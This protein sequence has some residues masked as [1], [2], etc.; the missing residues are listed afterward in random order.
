MPVLKLPFQK[1]IKENLDAI[2][3]L[4]PPEALESLVKAEAGPATLCSNEKSSTRQKLLAVNQSLK[5]LCNITLADAL[6]LLHLRPVS[7]TEQRVSFQ[8]GDLNIAYLWDRCTKEVCWQTTCYQG[9]ERTLRLSSLTDEGDVTAAL[10][11]AQHGLAVLI[12][13]DTQHKLQREQELAMGDV[14]AV[15]LAMSEAI[16]CMKFQSAPWSTGIFGRRIK[17]AKARIDELPADHLLVQICKAGII[18]D[19]GL[20]PQSSCEEIK[21]VITKH[22]RG[23]AEFHSLGGQNFKMS[24]WGDFVD[25]FSRIRKQWHLF[26]FWMLFALVLEG[27]SPWAALA[28]SLENEGKK[29]GLAIMPRVL[30]VSW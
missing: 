11:M 29:E 18:S 24:R 15:Q 26:L 27:Q 1:T 21:N 2:E 8:Y 4:P 20:D 5:N 13:R 9:F 7:P 16:L 22:A 6:P 10:Q 17:E 28:S 23:G 3:D 30:R 19:L 14:P 25:G 12:H